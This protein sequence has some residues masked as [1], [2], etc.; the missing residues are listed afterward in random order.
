MG[1]NNALEKFIPLR[2]ADIVEA[3][4][5]E[6]TL[7]AEMSEKFRRVAGLVQA[8]YHYEFHGT[9]MQARDAYHP[10]NPDADTLKLCGPD[11]DY[12]ARFDS[13]VEALEQLLEAANYR[14]LSLDELNEIMTEAAPRGLNIEVNR[15]KYEKILIY[16]RGKKRVQKTPDPA[17]WQNRFKKK[18][19]EP[20]T[21]E[22]LQ[23]LLILIKLKSEEDVE[24]FYDYYTETAGETG[25]EKKRR[26]LGE[27][28]L[29]GR[30]S[31]PS[32][33]GSKVPTIFLKVFKNVPVSTL[34]TLFPDV[35]IRMTLVDK[36]LILLPLIGGLFSVVNRVIP[37]LVVIGTVIAALALGR[38]INWSDFK[39]KLFPILAA[40]SVVGMITFKVFAKYKNTKEK[41][42]ARLMKTLYFHNL[43]N[44]AGVF[45][46]LVNE[47][48]E[49]ECKETI[50]AYYFLLAER[51]ASG[52]PFTLEELDD[53][54]E[55]WMQEKFGVAMDFEVD[56]A[57]RK[58]EEKGILEQKDGRYS[59]PS[60]R[61][62]LE[63]LDGLW[64]NFFPYNNEA[65]AES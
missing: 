29:G 9:L 1:E 8:I 24:A 21:E 4:C 64:D 62:T 44:N 52:Q 65:S 22:M 36:G 38:T 45:D 17:A 48:E 39:D 31:T 3:L 27:A 41:H 53:R 26:L 30:Q 60:I 18:K 16:R 61:K 63:T 33:K 14:E 6:K 13:M 12:S 46:F 5:S 19:T 15:E 43:D 56:D 54:I 10:F 35:T 40:F 58:L 50:L 32:E 37:A 51:N 42:Q 34:E 25:Q 7:S 59:V 2:T 55:E 57:V 23:R 49:E 47:A 28:A 11:E 20:E